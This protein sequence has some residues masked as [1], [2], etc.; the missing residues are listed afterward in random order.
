[1]KERETDMCYEMILWPHRSFAIE[2]VKFLFLIMFL[3][4]TVPIL[5][6]LGSSVGL[7]LLL[8]SMATLVIFGSFFIQSYADS[9]L[10]EIVKISPKEISVTRVEPN[11]EKNFWKANSYWAKIKLYPQG[12]IVENYLTLCGNNREIELGAYLSPNERTLVRE[13]LEIA[14]NRAKSH[15]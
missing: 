4:F 1:M 11:G 10:K 9:S 5:P 3:G 12:E 13:R 8:F 7:F 14:L 6:F 15:I 2:N